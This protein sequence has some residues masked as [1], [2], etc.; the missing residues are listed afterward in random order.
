[1]D[2]LQGKV[3]L[4][5]GGGSGI[6][7]ATSKTLAKYGVKVVVADIN[8]ESANKVA[9]EI[10]NNAIAVKLDVSDESSWNKAIA[11]TIE[12][13]GSLNVLVNNAG[14]GSLASV[15][16]ESL[17]GW[18]RTVAVNQTGVFLGMKVGGKAIKEHGGGSIIN[19]S[20]I[21]GL[22]GS[23]GQSVAYHAT[24]GAVRL[25]TKNAAIYWAKQ[26]V[27]VNSIHPGFIETPLL[28]EIDRAPL[29][30]HTPFGRLGE[31]QEIANGIAFLASDLSSYMTGSE[32]V[33]DGGW[34]AD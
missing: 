11:Q 21:Y 26:G 3:A 20:S 28:G 9:K 5:S 14:I 24:K 25:I 10:G 2:G 29:V 12:Q 15:E 30:G 32:M 27:R 7:E 18:N 31:P 23:F 6:G 34:T 22:V 13:F 17:E 33:I 19:V 4:V 8:D 1:M 16:D